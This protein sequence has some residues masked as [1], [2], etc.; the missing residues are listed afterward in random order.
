MPY[1]RSPLLTRVVFAPLLLGA[2]VLGHAAPS[3][4][5][6]PAP[7]IKLL[8]TEISPS[9]LPDPGVPMVIKARLTNTRTLK[10]VVRAMIV[11]DGRLAEVPTLKSYLNEKDL[12][13][14]EFQLSAPL[15][16]LT[17]RFIAYQDGGPTIA[18]PQY[19]VRR[20]CLPSLELTEPTIQS[21]EP[22]QQLRETFLKASSL[23]EEIEGYE[24]ARLQL[25][26][27]QK[28]LNQ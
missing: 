19:A 14:Y 28:L 27:L 16:E 12:P 8:A 5:T 17:Y 1:K 2:I 6:D 21:E 24:H 10:Y 22:T 13:T 9:E 23:A 15:A 18:S 25:E 20:K 7:S 4:A 11:R 3:H 26:E